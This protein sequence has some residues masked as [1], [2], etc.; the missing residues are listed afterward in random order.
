MLKA[1]YTSFPYF[2]I[3]NENFEMSHRE[4]RDVTS[5]SSN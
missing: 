4:K 5:N 2:F 3:A 1:L